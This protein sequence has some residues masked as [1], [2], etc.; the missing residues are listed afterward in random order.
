M[1]I[2]EAV[3]ELKKSLILGMMPGFD[4]VCKTCKAKS[5]AIRVL[6]K[7]DVKKIKTEVLNRPNVDVV[8]RHDEKEMEYIAQAIIDYLKGAIR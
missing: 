1:T 8:L 3:E 7:V 4:C 2:K 6:E 5:F